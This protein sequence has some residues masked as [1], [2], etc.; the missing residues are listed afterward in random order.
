[1]MRSSG[2]PV[3]WDEVRRRLSST[4][5]MLD[6]DFSP[7]AQAQER[8]LEER[9]RLLAQ[10]PQTESDA[11]TWEVLG[12]SIADVRYALE[13]EW[14]REI[15]VL[16]EL[17]PLPCTPPFVQGVVN[18]RGRIVSAVDLRCF[19]GVP[20]LGI[21]DFHRIIVLH[22]HGMEFGVLA[23]TIEGVAQVSEKDLRHEA[24]ALPSGIPAQFVKGVASGHGILLDAERL[25]CDPRMVVAQEIEA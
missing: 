3:D 24:A 4:E 10:E 17:T 14:V 1:M 21:V 5:Q 8:I 20:E 11:Q 19:W 6:E 7:S 25:L 13:A 15:V 12:F 2:T 23:D 16:K 22:G 9:A 18:I